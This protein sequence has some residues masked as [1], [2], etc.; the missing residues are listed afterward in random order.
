MRNRVCCRHCVQFTSVLMGLMVDIANRRKEGWWARAHN[1]LCDDA[2]DTPRSM[3][4]L[5]LARGGPDPGLTQRYY[6]C[7]MV[8][9]TDDAFIQ[10]RRDMS[11][12]AP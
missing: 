7:G 9:V 3:V 4:S 6:S 2:V 1:K 11:T 10:P 8:S 12:Q 5:T